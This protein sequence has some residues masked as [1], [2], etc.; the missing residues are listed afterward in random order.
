MGQGSQL[1]YSSQWEVSPIWGSLDMFLWMGSSV[2]KPSWWQ[3]D[4]ITDI[5]ACAVGSLWSV[6]WFPSLQYRIT[7]LVSSSIWTS[8]A[9]KG[10]PPLS[11]EVFASSQAGL[12]H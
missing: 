2:Y 6:T 12:I 10:P 8:T 3:A 4:R 1:L 9:P 7:S 11:T 5:S